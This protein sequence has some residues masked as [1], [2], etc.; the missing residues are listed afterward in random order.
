[1][2]DYANW[3]KKF[4]E[5]WKNLEGA[6]TT[7]LFSKDVQ[8]YETPIGDPCKTWDDVVA[9]WAVVNYNQKVISYSCNILCQTEDIC[10]VN[11]QMERYM[12]ETHQN[13]DGIFQISLDDEGKLTY[14]KQWRT[15]VNG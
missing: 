10:I 7:E 3:L 13:I 2:K 11:W 8:Y 12:G 9:L 6:K 14:F 5:S 1:M 4:M 15:T